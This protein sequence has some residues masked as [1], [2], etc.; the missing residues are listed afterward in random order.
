M[1]YSFTPTPA[2]TVEVSQNGQRISTTTPENAKLNYGYNPTAST[3]ATPTTKPTLTAQVTTP[4]VPP[5]PAPIV[6]NS[7]AAED[8]LTNVGTQIANLN[9]DAQTQT[10]VKSTP[11]PQSTT[12]DTTKNSAASETPTPED[13]ATTLDAQISD[14]L[15]NL[16]Q[17]QSDL[18]KEEQN[19]TTTNNEGQTVTFAQA[20][21][22]NQAQ[23]AEQYKIY[24]D[25]LSAISSGT[26]PLSAPEQ[27]LL[28]S[29]QN[30]FLQAIQQQQVANAAYTGQMAQAMASLGINQT[31]PTQ[32][33]GN[34][35]G[36]ISAG[37][38]RIAE[39]DSKMADSVSTL[40]LAFQK[41]DFDNVQTEWDNLSKHFEARQNTLATMQKAVT[42]GIKDQKQ[43]MVDF[44]KMT[45][46][47]ITNSTKFTY[48]QKQDLIDNTLKQAQFDEAQKK[49]AQDYYIKAQTLKL[50]QDAA[51]GTDG[52]GGPAVTMNGDGTVNKSQQAAFLAALPPSVASII[53]GIA[54][55]TINPASY[56]TSA[57]QA[58][59][60]LTRGQ[61]VALA[62]QYDPS[63]SESNYANR[64]ALVKN[65]TSGKYSQNINALNTAV[66]HIADLTD[67]YAGLGN[68]GFTPY[69]TAK[70]E[71]S[72]IFGSGQPG[73]AGLNIAAATG[74]L[75]SVFKSSG[76]TDQE[77][78]SLG[79]LDRNSSPEQVKAYQEAASQ[80]LASRLS[81]L[82]E[83]YTQ[84]MGKAPEKGFLS[85]SATNALLKLQQSGLDIKVPELARA[86]VIQL[87][88]FHDADP[89]NAQLIDSIMS[90]NPSYSPEDVVSILENQ[91][92]LQ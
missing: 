51:D 66:G 69:N 85:T 91:G 19:A 49:D 14:I 86:P 17:G 72:S 65:F 73:K 27:Q 54:N 64:Q 37:Q 57:K 78:N 36:A 61:I 20:Q 62:S 60:G 29:T 7:R 59:G 25:K 32:A 3:S 43:E 1:D 11:P 22:E 58:Q 26:Y 30:Q 48:Q 39:L 28:N 68:T 89:K 81:A 76:A 83:T 84:G 24:S 35:F 82:E 23:E 47:A 41:Q 46:D 53:Q 90:T 18:N 31:A 70:N 92:I 16:G 21:Q 42:D 4:V 50:Q 67:N 79:V 33:I 12:S 80:L 77:I 88:T 87:Q 8:H 13:S 55:Y 34:I 15:D 44:A 56:S 52:Y 5:K 74:E 45:I 40:Q 10:Q 63:Y 2:G 38:S 6:L 75:A 71:L 9:T